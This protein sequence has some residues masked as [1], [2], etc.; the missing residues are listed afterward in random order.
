MIYT[1]NCPHSTEM[2]VAATIQFQTQS[3]VPVTRL[4]HVAVLNPRL[5][6]SLYVAWESH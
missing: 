3:E 5:G 2:F 6:V 4:V 1:G